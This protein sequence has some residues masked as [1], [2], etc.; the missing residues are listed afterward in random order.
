[1]TAPKWNVKVNVTI[2]GTDPRDDIKYLNKSRHFGQGSSF[3]LFLAPTGGSKTR[4]V[5][6][7]QCWFDAYS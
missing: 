3:I 5:P 2:E 6:Q 4:A 1:M 7:L